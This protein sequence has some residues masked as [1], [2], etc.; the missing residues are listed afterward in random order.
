M[1]RR[2]L[3]EALAGPNRSGRIP[4][5]VVVLDFP[6]DAAGEYARIRAD[7]KRRGARIGA[8]DLFIPAHALSLGLTLVTNNATGFVRVEG[9]KLENWTA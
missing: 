9:L 4:S 1:W 5:L 3:P 2:D 8:N 7:L 6:E